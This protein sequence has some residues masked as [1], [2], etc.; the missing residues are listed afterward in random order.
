MP[1]VHSLIVLGWKVEYLLLR[2]DYYWKLLD[3]PIP[4]PI[5]NLWFGLFLSSCSCVQW[6]LGVE[7]VTDSFYPSI[8]VFLFS[9]RVAVGRVALEALRSGIAGRHSHTL[10]SK[11]ALLCPTAC[12]LS[13]KGKSDCKICC[14]EV[15]IRFIAM[16]VIKMW[17]HFSSW[18]IG[19][20]FWNNFYRILYVCLW[21]CRVNDPQ[22][23][24]A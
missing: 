20:C 4:M 3:V 18:M 9:L 8:E 2:W 13:S 16:P 23:L 24:V 14:P 5:W 12:R 19:S 6:I 10:F 15:V 22:N 17:P 21:C 7:C 1:R 11:Y